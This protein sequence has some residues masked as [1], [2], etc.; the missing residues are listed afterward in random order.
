M[1]KVSSRLTISLGLALMIP[2]EAY[3]HDTWLIPKFGL[4]GHALLLPGTGDFFPKPDFL[5]P[6]DRIEAIECNQDGAPISHRLDDNSVLGFQIALDLPATLNSTFCTLKL[7]REYIELDP[8]KVRLYL[9]DIAASPTLR[10]KWQRMKK[11]GKTWRENY[12]KIARVEF[13]KTLSNHSA[14]FNA[15]KP[16]KQIFE[17]HAEIVSVHSSKAPALGKSTQFVLLHRGKPYPN[18]PVQWISSADGQKG[19][20]R[21]NAKGIVTVPIQSSGHW[22]LRGTILRLQADQTFESDFF[23]LVFNVPHANATVP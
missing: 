10:E 7:E 13:G 4:P 6:K 21:T 16:S 11:Q 15:D 19:W 23:T 14:Q 22:M 17:P 5:T 12:T 1:R 9:D 18:Q 8:E 20:L 3:S 2:A